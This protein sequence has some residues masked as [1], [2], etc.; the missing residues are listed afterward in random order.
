MLDRP[1]LHADESDKK[2]KYFNGVR[3]ACLLARAIDV[4]HGGVELGLTNRLQPCARACVGVCS[5]ARPPQRVVRPPIYETLVLFFTLSILRS[6]CCSPY[7]IYS[8]R[9][10][11]PYKSQVGGPHFGLGNHSEVIELNSVQNHV[12][13]IEVTL[14][15]LFSISR[16]IHFDSF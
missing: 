9:I 12:T 1:L 13:S 2:G 3:M 8:T 15:D 4:T 5:A 14:F 10:S 16:L 7:A 6:P 11:A